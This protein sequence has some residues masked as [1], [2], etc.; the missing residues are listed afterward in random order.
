MF[1]NHSISEMER[2][3]GGKVVKALGYGA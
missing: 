3:P 2:L 1:P